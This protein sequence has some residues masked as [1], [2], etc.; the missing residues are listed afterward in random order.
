MKTVL[1]IEQDKTFKENLVELLELEGYKV[2]SA[3]NLTEAEIQILKLKPSVI[4]CDE[5]S[6][7][8]EFEKLNNALIEAHK[9]SGLI[10]INTDGTNQ[11]FKEADAYLKMPFRDDEL[12]AKM[13]SLLGHNAS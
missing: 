2:K 10:I 9:N 11:N 4:I 6:I 5:T 7:Y 8:G 1:I 3:S 13:N 12:L